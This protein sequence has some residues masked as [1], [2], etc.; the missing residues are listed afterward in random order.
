MKVWIDKIL[1]WIKTAID[2]FEIF[3][4]KQNRLSY[5]FYTTFRV[6]NIFNLFFDCEKLWSSTAHAENGQTLCQTPS[7]HGEILIQS[8]RYPIIWGNDRK[9]L[10]MI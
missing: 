9:G 1:V 6:L 7:S 10:M 2:I 3:S 8:K 5:I 4:K